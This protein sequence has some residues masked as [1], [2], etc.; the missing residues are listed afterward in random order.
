L[1]CPET[2]NSRVP[3]LLG[4]QTSLKAAAPCAMIQAMFD[5]DST[6]FTTVGRW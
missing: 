1:T 3:G 6:L 2:E 5:S 4:V